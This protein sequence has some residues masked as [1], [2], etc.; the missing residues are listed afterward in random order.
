MTKHFYG[1]ELEINAEVIA[2]YAQ[3]VEVVTKA[4]ELLKERRDAR[5]LDIGTGSGNIAVSILKNVANATGVATDISQ[6]AIDLTMVNAAKHG[7]ADRLDVRI[8]DGFK[9][10]NGRFD[11]IVCN[12]PYL[13]VE[14]A[15][16]RHPQHAYT[17]GKDGL[18][19][20][21]KIAANAADHLNADGVVVIEYT[22][23][24]R[25]EISTM[26]GK[27]PLIIVPIK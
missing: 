24:R 13:P 25:D 11:L 10:V 18:T 20:I 3:T 8:S 19:L 21:R 27:T 6:A 7:V 17:D 15:R 2:P 1:L 12:S 14:R 22:G 26:F 23:D 9:N 16:G 4:I 5:F